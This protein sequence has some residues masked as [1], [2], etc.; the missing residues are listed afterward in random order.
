VPEASNTWGQIEHNP[1][2]SGRTCGS[3]V[4]VGTDEG[5][6]RGMAH[7]QQKVCHLP[8]LQKGVVAYRRTYHDLVGDD[9]EAKNLREKV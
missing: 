4:R 1:E 8:S 9:L 5:K 6:Q 3:H 2:E 7:I